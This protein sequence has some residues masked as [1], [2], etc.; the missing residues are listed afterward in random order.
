M[1]D[2]PGAKDSMRLALAAREASV[3]IEGMAVLE[4]EARARAQRSESRPDTDCDVWVEIGDYMACDVDEFWNF[5]GPD[6]RDRGDRIRLP[7]G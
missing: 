5:V 6:Q 4:Q 3:V 7:L 2:E 1:L